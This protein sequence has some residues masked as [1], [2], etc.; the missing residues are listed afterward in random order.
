[1]QKTK[2]HKSKTLYKKNTNIITQITKTCRKRRSIGQRLKTKK[3]KK[4]QNT[5]TPHTQWFKERFYQNTIITH[6]HKERERERELK[7]PDQ[8]EMVADQAVV[9]VAT[10]HDSPSIGGRSWVR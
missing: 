1:M 4:N 10:Y 6:S 5:T 7:I 8:A 9:A 2:T 3:K